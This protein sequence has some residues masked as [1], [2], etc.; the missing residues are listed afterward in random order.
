MIQI[1]NDQPIC[2]RPSIKKQTWSEKRLGKQWTGVEENDRRKDPRYKATTRLWPGSNYSCPPVSSTAITASLCKNCIAS[3]GQ[4]SVN[5]QPVVTGQSSRSNW[6]VIVGRSA[7]YIHRSSLSTNQLKGH[8]PVSSRSLFAGLIHLLIGALGCSIL[9]L[10]RPTIIG[11]C[12][13]SHSI[14]LYKSP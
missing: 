4:G 8:A 13:E 14:L 9:H 6:T 3:M 10:L 11:D 7:N 2:N 12:N 1:R 5:Y